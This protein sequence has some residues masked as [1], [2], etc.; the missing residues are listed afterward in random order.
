MKFTTPL[1]SAGGALLLL[2]ATGRGSDSVHLAYHWHLHQPI[3][4]PEVNAGSAQ[5][6]RYQF[7]ADSISR[8]VS[9][10]G[11]YYAGSPYKHPRNL[12]VNGDGGEYDV[13]FDKDDRKQAYQGGGRS[14]IDT[15]LS[16]PDGGASVSYSGSLQENIWSLGSANSYG[17]GPG[18]NDGYR[19]ARGGSNPTYR[20]SGGYPR[21][22]LLGQTYHHAFSPLL[23]PSVLRKEIQIFKE[24]W[25]KSWGGNPDLSDHSKGFWPIECAFSRHMIP[26]LA[27]E[28][29]QW[30]IVANSHLARTCTNYLEVAQK[31]NSGWNMDPP[32][33]ADQ[34]GPFVPANQ[35][36]SGTQDGRGGAFPA[37]FAYQAHRAK[38]V[39]PATGV[40]S[41]ISIVPMCDLLSYKNG[42]A[43]MGTG[44][45]DAHIAPFNNPAQP[46]I[47]LM[48]HDGDNAWG[49]GA[50]YYQDSVHELFDAAASKGYRP[51]TIQQFLADHP[52][53]AGDVVHIEDGAW[54]NAEGD[55]GHPQ[56]I[57]WL[58]PPTRASSDPAYNS[59]DPRTW[60]DLE[61]PGWTEDWRN[62]AVLVAGANYCETAEQ[63]TLATGGTVQAAKIQEPVQRNGVN[64][65]P[66]AAEQ[67]WHYYLGGLDSGFMYYGTSL[68]DEVKQTLAVNRAISFATNAIGNA[69]LDTTPPT[70]FK[71]QRFPWNPGGKGWG[72]LTGYTP[73]G[74]EGRPAWSS[75]FHVWTH[76]FDVSGTTNVTLFVRTDLDGVNPIANNDNELYA[77]GPGV[78]SWVALPMNKRVI[79]S[80]NITGNGAVDFFLLPTA[81]AD[82]YWAKVTGYTNVLLDYY[83]MAVDSRGNTNRS[84]IQHVWVDAGSVE[85]PG[86]PRVTLTPAAPG[87]GD[88][89]T[90]SYDATTGPIAAANPVKLH[91]G[92]NRWAS[93]VSPDASLTFNAVSNRWETTVTVSLIAT[94]LD[95]AF[96]NGS[97]AWDNNGGA[98][99]HF[100]VTNNSP[101]PPPTTNFPA[102][103][104]DGNLDF[105]GYRVSSNGLGLYAALRG[106]QLYV[107]TQSPG[108][109]GPNDHYLFVSDQLLPAATTA[110]PWAKA[111]FIAVAS[112]KPYMATE[113]GNSYVAWNN[114]GAGAQIAKSA[115]TTGVFEGV[116]D[117][118]AAFG[119]VPATI[120]L[121]AAAYGTA[122][123]GALVNQSPAGTGSDLDPAEF[124]AIP[125]TALR[126]HNADGLFDRLDPQLDFTLHGLSLAGSNAVLTWAAMPGRSYRV[127]T[128]S[129]ATG[130]WTDVPASQT[131]AGPLQLDLSFGV[132]FNPGITQQFYRV[133]LLP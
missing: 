58:W 83:I 3:Y 80:G 63:I 49:G 103:T 28:G 95:L 44:E 43:P 23:P 17:Y 92:W 74:F 100:A 8:K 77:G 20:T 102:F 110:A 14:A 53:P 65:H 29:Y 78:G 57:N 113:S 87:A 41:F 117:L 129:A 56:F 2:T 35:W 112:S 47:V 99:W 111:G 27:A 16:H 94:Q 107:A 59:A 106:S 115:S 86:N 119:G 96:N 26:I 21:A 133:K 98:D 45:I 90:I 118:A 121:A 46:S 123:G 73:V 24:I 109:S 62:W 108:N 105:A 25:W 19:T 70:V 126:D 7:A 125:T 1:L 11:N 81:M 69:A 5:S 85:A 30:S 39:N 132:G 124:F 6:N 79:P 116:I 82:Y 52:V 120:Y 4:W 89:V 13:V 22:D 64:N 38:Y 130:P 131:N 61:T 128:A 101:P 71:P 104:L 12:L 31:G 33:R 18:W 50:S 32:N 127:L 91:L 42:Y 10:T 114:A 75:D 15:I 34:L 97:G 40:E 55:W 37:P 51:T 88:P 9:N 84:D 67:A 66:N 122:D 72:P 36:W 76:V 54:V 48:A 93:V 68:D 60:Y